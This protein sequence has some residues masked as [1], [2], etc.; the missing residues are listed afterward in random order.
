MPNIVNVPTIN[1]GLANLNKEIMNSKIANSGPKKKFVYTD[2]N[3][4]LFVVNTH[5]ILKWRTEIEG[6]II[7]IK[8][9][10]GQ[11]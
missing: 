11:V 10:D 1:V 4:I 2:Y 6:V 7:G 5:F 9:T 3:D 8:T